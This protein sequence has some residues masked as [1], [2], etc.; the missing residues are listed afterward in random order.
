MMINTTWLA[1]S[2][3]TTPAAFPAG[4]IQT[5]TDW[6]AGSKMISPAGARGSTESVVQ[7]SGKR[8]KL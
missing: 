3:T 8:I 1:L 4:L 2:A 7:P 6:S 5:R